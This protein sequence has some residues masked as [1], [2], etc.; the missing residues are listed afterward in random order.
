M[1]EKFS[2]VVEGGDQVGKGDAVC[3]LSRELANEGYDVCVVS[4]P[5]Y[6][7]PIGNAV[8]EVLTKDTFFKLGFDPDEEIS[9]KMALFALNR[10]EVLNSILQDNEDTLYV[11][12]R[13]PFSNALTIAYGIAQ[14]RVDASEVDSLVD[15]ALLLDS[16]FRRC[17]NSDRCVIKL[18]NTNR[19]WSGAREDADLHERTDVQELSEGIYDI[20]SE[21]LSSDWANIVTRDSNG[22]KSR[23]DILFATSSFV[24]FKIELPLKV[25]SKAPE[26]LPLSNILTNLYQG[27][28]LPLD[29]L[30]QFATSLRGNDKKGMYDA[31]GIIANCVVHSSEEIK[32]YNE[33]IKGAVKEILERNPGINIALEELYGEGFVIKLLKS[34]YD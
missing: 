8:R 24:K 13:G 23:E 27:S 29:S 33:E 21:R 14:G 28:L 4:F 12:D 1:N 7:T 2:V 30:E 34:I 15:E 17:M 31:S 32:W 16:F 3:N 26:Y 6:A 22:W 10:L 9:C 19:K 25:I 11:C 18:S 20:F 5:C